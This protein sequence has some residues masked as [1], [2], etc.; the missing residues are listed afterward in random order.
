[1]EEYDQ[2]RIIGTQG[3][4]VKYQLISK[5][6]LDAGKV[7]R[8]E[9]FGD[10]AICDLTVEYGF[11]ETEMTAVLELTTPGSYFSKWGELAGEDKELYFAF[12]WSIWRDGNPAD[13]L[14]I[15]VP[16]E[17]LASDG[18]YFP[19]FSTKVV[20]NDAHIDNGMSSSHNDEVQNITLSNQSAACEQNTNKC[21]FSVKMTRKLETGNF[22]DIHFLNGDLYGITLWGEYAID[23]ASAAVSDKFIAI[24]NG[25]YPSDDATEVLMFEGDYPEED[26]AI[27]TTLSA[28]FL[29]AAT[30]LYL[31]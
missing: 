11:T 26:N 25:E 23:G 10:M 19:N 2:S 29:A 22:D 13:G 16:I 31:N 4:S 28:G 24:V 27:M 17:G 3:K 30:L 5:P 7:T 8:D 15:T 14:K 20:G 6:L 21:V 9:S 12:L 1:M 18:A